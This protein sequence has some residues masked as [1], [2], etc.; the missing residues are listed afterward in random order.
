MIFQNQVDEEWRI[1]SDN[2]DFDQ[3]KN[4]DWTYYNVNQRNIDDLGKFWW[5]WEGGRL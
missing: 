3:E 5:K 1:E 2:F 4:C